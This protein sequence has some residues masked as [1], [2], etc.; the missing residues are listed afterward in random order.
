[1]ASESRPILNQFRFFFSV[2]LNYFIFFIH[3]FP[4]SIL[5]NAIGGETKGFGACEGVN[6]CVSWS[7]HPIFDPII[8]TWQ[9]PVLS[10]A[11]E[12]EKIQPSSSFWDGSHR[13]LFSKWQAP[14]IKSANLL[15][16]T[17]YNLVWIHFIEFLKYFCFFLKYLD[18]FS[19]EKEKY[20]WIEKPTIKPNTPGQ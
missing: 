6:R 3:Q 9:K 2:K 20:Y 14:C 18:A 4:I 10:N 1:M 12:E 19:N 17:I 8:R 5:Y 13:D 15:L 7:G 16:R 11:N